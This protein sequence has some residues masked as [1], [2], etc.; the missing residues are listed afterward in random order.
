[1]KR[2]SIYS[3]GATAIAALVVAAPATAQSVSDVYAGRNVTILVGYGAGGSYGQTAQLI[4]QY[5][6]RH[7]PGAPNVIVQ[8]MPGAGGIKATNYAYNV[9]PKNGTF[10]LMPPEMTVVSQLD[11]A[12]R[13]R[14]RTR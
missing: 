4:S 10:V 14:Y 12:P 5:F 2:T 11:S 6:G 9:M 7:I 13:C 8:H 1:M 3:F